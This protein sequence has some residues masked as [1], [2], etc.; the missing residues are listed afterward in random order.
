MSTPLLPGLT[1]QP[2]QQAPPAPPRPELEALAAALPPEI[3]IGPSSW[4]YPGW[5]ELVW[6]RPL[7]E[8]VLAR[9]GLAALNAWPL[10]RA[11]GVDRT[12][13]QPVS[14]DHYR[15]WAEMAPDLRFLVKA[16]RGLTN[17]PD[18]DGFL[19][20]DHARNRLTQPATQGLGA[21]LGF[22]LFQFP[23]SATRD[24]GGATRFVQRLVAFLRDLDPACRPAVELRDPALVTPRVGDALSEAGAVPCLDL[25]PG[26][27]PLAVQQRALVRPHQ[28]LVVRW[29][30]RPG[31]T[32]TKARALFSPYRHLRGADPATRRA[33]ALAAVGHAERGRPVLITIANRAEGSIPLSAVGLAEQIVALRRRRAR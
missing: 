4:A 25:Q 26:L 8:A 7:P 10:F 5:G 20:V 33:L 21:A 12:F 29:M 31:L 13:H 23:A 28:P 17:A 16:P 14:A 2:L 15:A 32:Y 6:G 18:E 11:V 19:S 1:P 9:F 27:P 24:A 30:T 3:R 22:T